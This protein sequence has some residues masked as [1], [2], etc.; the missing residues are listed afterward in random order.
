M[1]IPLL[2]YLIYEYA[3]ENNEKRE[4][5]LAAGV[6]GVEAMAEGLLT[7]KNKTS[8]LVNYRFSTTDILT[9]W[10]NVDIGFSGKP[11]YQD[12]AYQNHFLL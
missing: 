1:E 4:Y 9:K 3:K 8:F 5:Q 12:A 7:K 6:L 10:V 2:V 11:I